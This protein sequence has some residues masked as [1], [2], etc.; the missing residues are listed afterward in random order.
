MDAL[1]SAIFDR[2]AG[3]ATLDGLLARTVIGAG[4]GP[5][6]YSTIP[7]PP[8]AQLPY[9][10]AYAGDVVSTNEDPLNAADGE[11]RRVTRDISC[12]AA[13]PDDG[14][15]DP[16]TVQAIGARIRALFH[17]APLALSD[18]RNLVAQAAGPHINDGDNAFGR[19]VSVTFLL[20]T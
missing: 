2:L 3:D 14:G 20:A 5:A 18:G 7:V 6:I 13:R 1:S 17:R 8:T 12:Y 10:V 9:V 4:T 15:G 11:Y 19:V 16:S